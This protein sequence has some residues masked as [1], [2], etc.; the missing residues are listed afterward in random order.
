LRSP[1][2][3]ATLPDSADIRTWSNPRYAKF[4]LI[5]NGDSLPALFEMPQGTEFRLNYG[6]DQM[7]E[8]NYGDTVWVYVLFNAGK[9]LD[10]LGARG[11]WT[12]RLDGKHARYVLF[13]PT[14]NAQ[15][16]NGLKSRLPASFDSDSVQVR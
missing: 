16:W 8:W 14:E 3:F 6:K 2:G 13:S 7:Q 15:A 4:Y 9:W 1:E 5:Q 12:T 11:A 10:P